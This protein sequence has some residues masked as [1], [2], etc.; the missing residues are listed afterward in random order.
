M[1]N[2]AS[3][4]P[5][6]HLQHSPQL[7]RVATV[8]W[9]LDNSIAAQVTTPVKMPDLVSALIAALESNT[10]TPAVTENN[11]IYRILIAEDNMVNQKL[12]MKILEKF[13]HIVEIVE[14]GQLAV[15]QFIA[16]CEREEPYDIILV[17]AV[18]CR[19]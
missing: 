16:R 5:L 15:D 4:L 6:V 12:A 10:V 3:S 7:P 19:C 14:N 8:K 2:C 11:I 13:G 17:S 9:C 1:L 18:N